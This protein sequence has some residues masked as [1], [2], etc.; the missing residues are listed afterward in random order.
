V[1]GEHFLADV[2]ARHQLH[3]LP[4]QQALAV[5]LAA[6]EQHLC[7][8]QVVFGRRIQSSGLGVTGALVRTSTSRLLYQTYPQPIAGCNQ[9]IEKLLGAFAPR[10]DPAQ[11]PLP[12]DRKRNRNA[13]KK[14]NKRGLPATGFDLRTEAYKLFGVDVTQAPGVETS[15]LPRFSEVGRDLASRCGPPLPTLPLG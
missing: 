4:A 7:E 12:A 9:E 8:L 3:G 6:I 13:S 10:V 1:G 14:G 11:K 5:Q 15:V 2:F